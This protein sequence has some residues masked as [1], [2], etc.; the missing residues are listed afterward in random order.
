[1]LHELLE[2]FR[3]APNTTL[4][5]AMIA[6]ELDVAP[7]MLDHMLRTLVRSGRL[8]EVEHCADCAA[9]PLTKICVGGLDLRQRGYALRVEC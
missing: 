9:C 4:T 5:H 7:G 8:V 1:M 3:R 2:I 6:A